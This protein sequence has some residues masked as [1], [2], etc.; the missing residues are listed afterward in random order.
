VPI[1]EEEEDTLRTIYFSDLHSILL[2]G[3]IF[4]GNS[5]Y[6]SNIFKKRERER[7]RDN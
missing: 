3:V 6:S 1:E 4:W 7:E 5:A 2:Y